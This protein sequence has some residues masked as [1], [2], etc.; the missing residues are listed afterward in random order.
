MLGLFT[1]ILHFAP[2]TDKPR[3]AKVFFYYRIIRACLVTSD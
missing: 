1:T 3:K 2:S